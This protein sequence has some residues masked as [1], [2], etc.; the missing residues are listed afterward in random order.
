MRFLEYL[1]TRYCLPMYLKRLLRYRFRLEK[2][3]M[4]GWVQ[5]GAGNLWSASKSECISLF[6]EIRHGLLGW[7]ICYLYLCSK[8][9]QKDICKSTCSNIHIILVTLQPLLTFRSTSRAVRALTFLGR[10][11]CVNLTWVTGHS[12]VTGNERA[13]M[14]IKRES[15]SQFVGLVPVME[16]IVDLI[17]KRPKEDWLDGSVLR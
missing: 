3:R 9:C 16:S 10:D 4:D 2:K 6:E 5:D 7:S 13:D 14:L 1:A 17:K 11:N 12:D 15:S 8:G